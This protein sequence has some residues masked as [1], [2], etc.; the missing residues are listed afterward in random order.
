L[1]FI[2]LTIVC[3]DVNK[4]QTHKIFYFHH[5]I[6]EVFHLLECYAASVGSLLQMFWAAH[7]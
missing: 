3:S 5:G 4:L 1:S 7:C 2:D 6:V